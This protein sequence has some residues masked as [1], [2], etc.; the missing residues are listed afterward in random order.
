VVRDVP[1]GSRLIAKVL[2][3]YPRGPYGRVLR[4]FMPH[5]DLFMFRKQL[6]TLQRYAER[7]ARNPDALGNRSI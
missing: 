2:V 3:R 4:A 1:G 6:L 5:A 7:D